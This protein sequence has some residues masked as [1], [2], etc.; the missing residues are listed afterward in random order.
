[1]KIIQKRLNNSYIRK[2]DLK[3]ILCRSKDK[4]KE[5]TINLINNN[6]ENKINII[7]NNIRTNRNNNNKTKLVKKNN[8]VKFSIPINIK[9]NKSI[10]ANKPIKNNNMI[11]ST[12]NY[13]NNIKKNAIHRHTKSSFIQG[14]NL[15]LNKLIKDISMTNINNNLLNNEFNNLNTISKKK[16][17][18]KNFVNYSTRMG[19][20]K[21]Y[22]TK[23]LNGLN[24]NK[25][26]NFKSIQIETK[27]NKELNNNLI[28]SYREPIN[29]KGGI[30]KIIE[31]LKMDKNSNDNNNLY[32]SGLSRKF[33]D[34]QNNWRKNYFATVIQKLY[35][36]YNFRKYYKEFYKNNQNT[37]SLRTTISKTN[38]NVIN[39]AIVYIK[40]KTKDNNYICNS[41]IHHKEFPTEENNRFLHENNIPHK[42]KEIVISIKTKKEHINNNN[43]LYYNNYI[44]SNLYNYLNY[45]NVKY[46]FELWKEYSDKIEILKKLKIYKRSKKNAFR[47]SSYE[48]QRSN[49]RYKI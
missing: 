26:K 29:T 28:N 17:S 19:E 9:N 5:K 20:N 12:N 44:N 42:I 36:G 25:I 33:I 16:K 45:Y 23:M 30:I 24:N 47:K 49:N 1:M 40:K 10:L 15:Q 27:Q 43:N 18:L 22:N 32:N 3:N 14:T 13:N 11:M 48:K 6:G 35:R 39:N 41:A 8:K 7:G 37:L 38:K 21:R 31:E 4:E 46:V 34:A 2:N